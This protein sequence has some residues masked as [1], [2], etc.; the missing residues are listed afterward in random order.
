MEYSGKGKF[1]WKETSTCHVNRKRNHPRQE[2]KI[3]L[4]ERGKQEREAGGVDAT[5]ITGHSEELER[6]G[7]KT[8]HQVSR[9][10]YN[11]RS[12]TD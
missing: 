7:R 8:T 6:E 1:P 11:K 4:H 9:T 5:T 2:S 10:M 12:D 3:Y